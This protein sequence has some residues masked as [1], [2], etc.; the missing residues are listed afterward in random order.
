MSERHIRCDDSSERATRSL[1]FDVG[2]I[3]KLEKTPTGG[4]RVPARVTRTG[5]FP[6]MR[7]DGSIQREY[8]PASEVF[9][10]DSLASLA[11]AA[12][13]VEHPTEGV[14][15]PETFRQLAAG[16]VREGVRQDGNFVAAS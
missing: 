16:Y 7:A 14:V 4:V 3:G 5:V 10:A 12:V 15:T 2:V 6:Y 1:R 8:R 11:D 13:T 9:K